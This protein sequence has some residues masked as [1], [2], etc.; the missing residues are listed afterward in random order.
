MR[1]QADCL[2]IYGLTVA[3]WVV[4]GLTIYDKMH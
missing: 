3:I 4:L 2:A 1:K